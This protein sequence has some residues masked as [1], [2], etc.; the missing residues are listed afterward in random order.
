[1]NFG[2]HFDRADLQVGYAFVAPT[3]RFQAG[4]SNNVGSG[5]WGNDVN[6]GTTA[7][8]TKNKGTSANLYI[9]WEGHG[10]KSGTNLTPGQAFT[11]EW[12]LGQA[13]PLKK[14]QSV[15][16]QL[17]FVGYDQRQVSNN[18]GTLPVA[19]GTIPARLVPFYSV[20][21]Y[22]I[23]TNLIAPKPGLLGFFKYYWEYSAS[24]RVLGR[25]I[26]FGFTWTFKM[27]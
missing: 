17:G 10:K 21:S 1:M 26:V 13:L 9:D 8:I 7:Y 2:W 11:M 6:A 14:D 19:T 16:A 23:Q 24:S 22:G 27:P 5:Y 3:G 12:G 15:I 18:G 25:T 4:A 20:H